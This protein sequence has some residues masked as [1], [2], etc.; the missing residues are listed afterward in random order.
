[1]K[2]PLRKALRE[3][4]LISGGW[5]LGTCSHSCAKVGTEARVAYSRLQARVRKK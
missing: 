3:H 2:M 5:R 4:V 1:M